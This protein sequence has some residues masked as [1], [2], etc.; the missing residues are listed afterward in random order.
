MK[1]YG[2][3]ERPITHDE[4]QGTKNLK[5]H[6]MHLGA[7]DS[8]DRYFEQID[9][10]ANTS[11]TANHMAPEELGKSDIKGYPNRNANSVKMPMGMQEN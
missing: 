9:V 3:G 10:S 1:T 11:L 6:A 2:E 7:D 5:D 4:Y 8:A